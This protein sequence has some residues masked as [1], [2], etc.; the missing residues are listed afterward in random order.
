MIF[1]CIDFR[2]GDVYLFHASDSRCDPDSALWGLFDRR[3]GER[4]LLECYTTDMNHFEKWKPLPA[5][6]RFCRMATRDELRDFTANMIH[7]EWVLL[8]WANS[9]KN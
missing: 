2:V 8:I 3:E 6:Y 4:I 1:N 7:A 9:P 5:G